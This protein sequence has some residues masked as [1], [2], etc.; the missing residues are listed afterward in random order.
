MIALWLVHGI[1]SIIGCIFFFWLTQII[2]KPTLGLLWV[3][4]SNKGQCS[5][6]LAVGTVVNV[7]RIIDPA[8]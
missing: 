7:C 4:H 3:T 5:V 8:E 2:L 6:F 1:D